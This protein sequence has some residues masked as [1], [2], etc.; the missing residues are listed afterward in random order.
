MKN[1]FLILI[2]V[3][4]NIKCQQVYPLNTENSSDLP[5][6]SY[7]KD[8]DGELNPY[9]GLWK[10]NWEGKTIYLEL[11]K[12]KYFLGMTPTKGRYY[13]VI[14]GERK[15]LDVNGAI[16][17]DRISSFDELGS[18][19]FGIYNKFSNP[20]QKQ[21]RFVPKNM[22]GATASLDVTFVNPSKTQM[23]VH[24]EYTPSYLENTCP[25]YDLVKQGGEYPINFPKDIVLT[26]Q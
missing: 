11:R 20:I 4:I 2:F 15:V 26:K 12:V 16:L 22:C 24:F 8:F 10:G 5:Y 19:F 9:I 1:I 18:E 6:G 3:T 23:S 17:I 7:F 21:I 13:D 25:Y 14:L